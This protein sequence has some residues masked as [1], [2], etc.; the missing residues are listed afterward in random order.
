MRWWVLGGEKAAWTAAV[1]G[2]RG[3]LVVMVRA[4][5]GW[6]RVVVVVVVLVVVRW[7]GVVV[8]TE[9]V[10]VVVEGGFCRAEWA[11][12]AARKLVRK[13]RL[14]GIVDFWFVWFVRLF[15]VV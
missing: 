3:D 10:V 8:L 5:V 12:K 11:R 9:G 13:G 4:L 2:E 6:E 15:R 7:V 14:V 1:V